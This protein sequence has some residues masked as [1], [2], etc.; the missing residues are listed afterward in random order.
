MFCE[1]PH[2]F[3]RLRV[4]TEKTGEMQIAFLNLGLALIRFN[5]L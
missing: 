4:V 2:T 5:Y 3:R 1:F